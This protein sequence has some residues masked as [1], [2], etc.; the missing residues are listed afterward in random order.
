MM[1]NASSNCMQYTNSRKHCFTTKSHIL[2]MEPIERD[3]LEKKEF[4]NRWHIFYSHIIGTSIGFIRMLVNATVSNAAPR[5]Q[6]TNTIQV[7]KPIDGRD[8][9][10]TRKPAQ[11]LKPKFRFITQTKLKQNILY[12]LRKCAC[13]FTKKS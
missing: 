9:Q 4:F 3:I 8:C 1:L 11:T 10:T 6:R 12:R 13:Y 5:G 7:I 2:H